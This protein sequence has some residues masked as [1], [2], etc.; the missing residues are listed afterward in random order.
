MAAKQP[1]IACGHC[2]SVFF[3]PVLQHG[4]AAKCTRC[5][6]VLW[7]YSGLDLSHWLALGITTVI[8]FV[9][10]NAYPVASLNV[11]GMTQQATLLDA[12]HITWTQGH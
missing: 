11:Q 6:S 10:A 1:L 7:R 4:E 9:L 2:G 12:V 8:L 5:D 3:R